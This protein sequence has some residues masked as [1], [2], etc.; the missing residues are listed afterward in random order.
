MKRIILL[1]VLVLT[2]ACAVAPA[3]VKVTPYSTNCE[4]IVNRGEIDAHEVI[5]MQK[6]T[7]YE[8]I[9]YTDC[10]DNK[11]LIVIN[12]KGEYT[13]AKINLAKQIVS[14]YFSHFY[15]S[16]RVSYIEVDAISLGDTNTVVFEFT[17]TVRAF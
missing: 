15:P 11:N 17:K 6:K 12:W 3:V 2:S 9:E 7:T 5:D 16:V 14:N 8:A 4:T 13:V 1:I 10:P